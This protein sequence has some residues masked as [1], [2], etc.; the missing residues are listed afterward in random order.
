MY[1]KCD[2]DPFVGWAMPHSYARRLVTHVFQ[3][4][5]EGEMTQL[6]VLGMSEAFRGAAILLRER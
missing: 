6:R 5:G 4:L 3:D 1:L 2:Y